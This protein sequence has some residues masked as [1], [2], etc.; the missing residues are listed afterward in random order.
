MNLTAAQTTALT[1]LWEHHVAQTRK[2]YSPTA[3]SQ[4]IKMAFVEAQDLQVRVSGSALT[5][6]VNKGIVETSD[7]FARVQ[8][9]GRPA[10]RLTSLGRIK[11]AAL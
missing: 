11:A 7:S 1:T 5:A 2:A 6:L 8:G 9:W 3:K 10:Y 4:N